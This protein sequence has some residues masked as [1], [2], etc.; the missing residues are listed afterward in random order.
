MIPGPLVLVTP[1]SEYPGSPGILWQR[2]WPVWMVLGTSRDCHSIP[3]LAGI[4]RQR[5][6]Q[7]GWSW[8]SSRDG[9]TIHAG[10]VNR[11]RYTWDVCKGLRHSRRDAIWTCMAKLVHKYSSTS[12]SRHS[13]FYRFVWIWNALASTR[14]LPLIL[15]FKAPNAKQLFFY[16]RFDPSI[17]CSYHF[18]CPCNKCIATPL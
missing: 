10:R 18:I 13:Y 8:E 6:N 17:P 12:L 15:Q 14:P 9:P 16:Q 11:R 7:Y 3:G 5:V 2:V 1:L 4:L